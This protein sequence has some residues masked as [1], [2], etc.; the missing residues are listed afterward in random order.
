MSNFF[1]TSDSSNKQTLGATVDGMASLL[2]DAPRY[3]VERGGQRS[4]SLATH[5]DVAD[6]LEACG[7]QQES[8]RWHAGAR[9]NR[10]SS[11]LGLSMY[12][13]GAALAGRGIWL[14]FN[15]G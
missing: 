4:D 11:G 5:E 2:R 7:I 15:A 14:V 6:F 9:A 10:A 12:G 3:I 8:Q 13:L 1:Q